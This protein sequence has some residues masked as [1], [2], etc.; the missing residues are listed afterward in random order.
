MLV[1]ICETLILVMVSSMSPSSGNGVRDILELIKE[2]SSSLKALFIQE[3]FKYCTNLMSF[4]DL[5]HSQDS[6]DGDCLSLQNARLIDF[7]QT[8]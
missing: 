3:S 4:V 7:L 1:S 5:E 8:G 6:Y 2:S